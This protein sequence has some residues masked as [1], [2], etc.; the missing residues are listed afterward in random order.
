MDNVS[1]VSN[2]KTPNEPQPK[3]M[4]R[5]AV[6]GV[7]LALPGLRLIDGAVKI[8]LVF[9]D[10]VGGDFTNKIAMTIDKVDEGKVLDIPGNAHFEIM[11]NKILYNDVEG[12][13]KVERKGGLPVDRFHGTAEVKFDGGKREFK[14]S[15]D[16][17]AE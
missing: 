5:G 7:P 4:I 10:L 17:S 15:F 13:V 9:A 6:D 16:L 2:E 14:C 11:L 1:Q 3:G 8:N 12:E